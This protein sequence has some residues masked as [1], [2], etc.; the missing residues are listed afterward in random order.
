MT[1]NS[2][3]MKFLSICDDGFVHTNQVG[4]ILNVNKAVSDLT[5]RS[6]EEL[7]S[8]GIKILFERPL[9]DEIIDILKYGSDGD[10]EAVRYGELRL[11]KGP[12]RYVEI[13]INCTEDD[14]GKFYW[15]QIK[16]KSFRKEIEQKLRERDLM[17]ETIFE[18]LPFDFWINDNE[19]KTYMQN[20]FSKALW[21]DVKGRHPDEVADN[22]NV[23]EYW[24]ET[25]EKA[26]KGEVV[27]GEISYIVDGRTKYFKNI[28]A[29]IHDEDRIFGILGMNIDITDLKEALNARDMLL[30]EIHHR[31]KNNL[32]MIISII[33][34]ESSHPCCDEGA[35]ILADIISRI[36]AVSLI[37]EKLYATDSNNLV[38]SADYLRELIDHLVS[39]ITTADIQVVFELEDVVLAIDRVLVLGLITNEL[40]TNAVKYAFTS[41]S[42]NI[43]FVT[44]EEKDDEITVVIADNGPGLPDGFDLESVRS[45]GFRMINV[46][47]EQLGG[48]VEMKNA[49]EGFSV[50]IRFPLK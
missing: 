39:N 8:S 48:G 22:E 28:I 1:S 5:G 16:N 31:V 30:K 2:V 29:P 18:S 25:T 7:T 37:H 33:N 36:E 11:K 43:L 14:D 17:L 32:Q 41:P 24:L 20:S 10:I 6:S 15:L 47:A 38:H 13:F 46:L 27:S 9:F 21:G 4:K 42:G 35:G 50:F 12:P 26:L 40:V 34:L 44:L 45:L 19:N 23:V 3:Y 49:P